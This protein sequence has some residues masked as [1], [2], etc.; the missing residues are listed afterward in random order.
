MQSVLNLASSSLK[1]VLL[2]NIYRLGRQAI[3]V[4]LFDYLKIGPYK[5]LLLDY[6][7]SDIALIPQVDSAIGQPQLKWP[8]TSLSLSD[9]LQPK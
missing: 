5:Q 6:L 7:Q 1:D 3:I 2:K 9:Y 8:S 4:G